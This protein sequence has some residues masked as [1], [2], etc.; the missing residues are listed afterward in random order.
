MLRELAR[1]SLVYGVAAVLARFAGFLLLPIYARVLAADEIGAVD[2]IALALALAQVTVALEVSQGFS[3]FFAERTDEAGRSRLAATATA[4]TV[5]AYTAF[6]LVGLIGAQFFADVLLGGKYVDAVRVAVGTAW[7]AGLLQLVLN[8][9]RYQLRPRAYAS[10]NVLSIL[11]SA[12]A[13]ILFVVGFKLGPTGVLAGQLIGA[14]VA[15]A[16]ALR[17]TGG[18]ARPSLHLPD[19]GEMLRFS[20]PLVPSSLGV[21]VLISIDRVVIN[22]SLSLGDVGVFGVA[23]RIAQLTSIVMLGVQLALTPL[24]YQRYLDPATPAALA[25][26]FRLFAAGAIMLWMGLAAFAPLIVQVLATDRYL[27]AV[28]LVPFL[29]GAVIL[30]AAQVFAPGLSLAMRTSTIAAINIGGAVLNTVLNVLLVPRFGL[31]AAAASTLI[32]TIMVFALN[33]ALGQRSYRVPFAW[34]K[35]GGALAVAVVLAAGVQSV[36]GWTASE[37]GLRL[38]A[39]AAVATFCV[40]VGL[41]RR[42]DLSTAFTV[43][44]PAGHT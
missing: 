2:L 20:L 38:V 3:R 31:V 30:S 34:A 24:I 18:I 44:R 37:I 27:P 17:F 43:N 5:I 28:P 39:V 12:A 8:Q 32:S 1:D 21:I 4:F 15:L 10:I 19:L 33:A 36:A 14:A 16:V 6:V 40:A 13:A 22:Q 35:I 9:L 23:Y 42:S 29:A 41:V 26:I 11:V 25:R 7:F